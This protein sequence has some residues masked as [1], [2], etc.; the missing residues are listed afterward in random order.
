MSSDSGLTIVPKNLS[1]KVK[2][3][4]LKAQQ[5][6]HKE[7]IFPA[8]KKCSDLRSKVSTILRESKISKTIVRYFSIIKLI[9]YVKEY[10]LNMEREVPI[11]KPDSNFLPQR[12]I[13]R[14][15]NLTE[16]QEK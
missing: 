5:R 2:A 13:H 16:E 3:R 8:L 1:K 15:S 7:I 12:E 6:I 11:R 10:K 4:S 9:E 14:Y